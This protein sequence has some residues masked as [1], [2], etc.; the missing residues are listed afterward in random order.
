MLRIPRWS[1]DVGLLFMRLSVGSM[2]LFGHGLPKL[3]SFSEHAGTFSDPLGVGSTT[4]LVLAICG[5][6]VGSSL[7]IVGLATR[8]SVVPLLVTMLVAATIV[9]AEDPWARKEFALLYAIPALTLVLTGAG[10]FSIDGLLARRRARQ[11]GESEL[12]EAA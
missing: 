12:A 4:S 5:E 2:M 9:H 6:V 7:V 8:V 10:R 3:M 11:Q 1:S